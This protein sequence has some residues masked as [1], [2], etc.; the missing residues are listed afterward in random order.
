ME[1]HVQILSDRER[2]VLAMLADGYTEARISSELHITEQ[3][4]RK[5]IRNMLFKQG[6]VSSYQ[7]INWAYKE[8][9]IS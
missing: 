1:R 3:T 6:F 4:V 9:V 8:A 2:Q 7:L 5:H